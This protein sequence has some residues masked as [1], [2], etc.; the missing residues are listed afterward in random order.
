MAA[1]HVEEL[2]RASRDLAGAVRARARLD[3]LD[4]QLRAVRAMALFAPVPRGWIP[5]GLW[6]A[7]W[8]RAEIAR[9][10]ATPS[11]FAGWRLGWW[12]PRLP[13]AERARVLDLAI[14]AFERLIPTPLGPGND[15]GPFCDV[16][17]ALSLAQTRRAVA[18]VERMRAASWGEEARHATSALAARLVALGH[19]AEAAPLFARAGEPGAPAQP[20]PNP[21]D[22]RDRPACVRAWN[23]GLHRSVARARRA[24]SAPGDHATPIYRRLADPRAARLLRAIAGQAAIDLCRDWLSG[25]RR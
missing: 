8:T 25:A 22:A 6:D 2:R 4:R 20:T 13:R 15:A 1:A 23:A 7:A 17:G 10:L 19:A 24:P 18:I 16:A 3:A 11:D 14:D 5:E 21:I 12:A 9:E